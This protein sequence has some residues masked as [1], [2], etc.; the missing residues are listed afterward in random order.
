M[1]NFKNKNSKGQKILLSLVLAVIFL[2]PFMAQAALVPCGKNGQKA[3]N[4]C[5]LVVGIQGLLKY[6]RDIMTY[7][8]LAMICIGGIIYII[9]AGNEKLMTQAKDLLWKVLSGFAIIL[10]AWIIVTY[11]LILLSHKENLGVEQAGTWSE[12]KCTSTSTPS[13]P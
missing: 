7:A 11:S 3:C 10:A 6:G 9:S 13:Q 5:D 12:F 1:I 4:L 2:A 8:A